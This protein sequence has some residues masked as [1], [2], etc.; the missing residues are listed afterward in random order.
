MSNIRMLPQ[1]EDRPI[2]AAGDWIAAM[3]RG[4]SQKEEEELG[5]WL[6]SD[7]KKYDELMELARLWDE[8]DALERLA[9][10]FPEP[11]QTRRQFFSTRVLATAAS[12]VVACSVFVVLSTSNFSYQTAQEAR[13]IA[14]SESY[15]TE[16]GE[17]AEYSLPD[18][19]M[20]T[21]NTNSGV[22]ADFTASNRV[23]TLERGELHIAVAH[24]PNRP[25]SVIVGNKVVQAVGTEFNVEITTDNSIELI[26][27]DGVVMVG[28]AELPGVE[29]SMDKPLLLTQSSTIVVAGE[30]VLVRSDDQDA[31]PVDA[32]RVASDEIAVKLSWREGNLIF[33]GESLEEAV[34]EVERYTAVEFIFL[35]E[36][37][38][39]V[40]VAGLFKAGDV[41]GLLA[42]FRDH[43]RITYEWQGE[44]RILL[45]TKE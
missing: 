33:R 1:R 12:L 45:S 2:K 42:A 7:S 40:R 23:L 30:R 38:K 13:S 37:A 25:L 5:A 39:K 3:E 4:L 31:G 32:G 8:M 6:S 16:I 18:G 10:L 28:V 20:I 29:V 44:D 24:D 19:S 21:L 43:F 34:T 26:V 11:E 27:T 15:E 22:H 17:R 41:E 36:D 35:D 9:Q 14:I